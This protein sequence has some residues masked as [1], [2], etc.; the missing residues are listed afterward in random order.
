MGPLRAGFTAFGRKGVPAEI[1]GQEAAAEAIAFL[2]SG[3][4]IEEHLSDQLLL[5][6]AL[7]GQPASYTTP[8]LSGHLETNASVIQQL[9][10]GISISFTQ[11][12]DPFPLVRVEIQPHPMR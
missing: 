8:Q 7:S 12:H 5:P 11:I 9:M 2:E 3:A 10:P 1:I 4:C 6:L